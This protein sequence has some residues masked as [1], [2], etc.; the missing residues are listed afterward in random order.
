VGVQDVRPASIPAFVAVY[1]VTAFYWS[2]FVAEWH[3]KSLLWVTGL[4]VVYGVWSGSRLGLILGV[5]VL[6]GFTFVAFAAVAMALEPGGHNPAVHV[7]ET[8]LLLTLIALLAAPP[9]R[10]FCAFRSPRRSRKT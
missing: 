7:V 2:A 1:V 6:G 9:T 3:P 5:A 8:G 4:G 10:R